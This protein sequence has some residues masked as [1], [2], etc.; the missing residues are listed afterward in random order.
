MS[1]NEENYSFTVPE[2]ESYLSIENYPY[3]LPPNCIFDKGKVGCGATTIALKCQHDYVIAVP[4]IFLIRNKVRQHPHV[5]GVDG[6]TSVQEIQK[7]HASQEIRT[8][9]VTY[10][11]LE[12][13]MEAVDTSQFKLLV[14]EYHLLFTHYVFR[15]KAIKKVLNNFLKFKEYCFMSATPIQPDFLLEELQGI[16]IVTA[17]WTNIKKVEIISVRCND[18]DATISDK[19]RRFLSG[20]LD[21]NAYIFVNS[22]TTI[23]S[24][25]TKNKLTAENTRVIYSKNNKSEVGIERSD[26]DSEPKKINLL[27]SAA[28][29]GADI[30]DENGKT[31][32][33]SNHRKRNTLIDISTSVLQISGRIRNTKYG[34]KVYHLYSSTR[35]SSDVTY[36]D[37]KASC[38]N[39]IQQTCED[40]EKLNALSESTKDRIEL[41]GKSGYLIKND[42]NIFKYDPNLFRYDLYNFNLTRLLYSSQEN[43]SQEYRNR[44]F[45]VK[46]Q[47]STKE[48]VSTTVP[49]E[50]KLSYK[51]KVEYVRQYGCYER[52]YG[53]SDFETQEKIADIFKTEPDLEEAILSPSIGFTGIAKTSYQRH[54]VKRLLIKTRNTS[55]TKK[56][57]DLLEEYGL[58]EAMFYTNP[59][60]TERLAKVYKE[61]DFQGSSTATGIK[62]F[63]DT[64]P[65]QQIIDGRRQKGFVIIR[66]HK[67]L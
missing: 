43:L 15:E 34:D 48:F 55:K 57:A 16:P 65:A 46:H 13:L 9:M 58:Q 37:Y 3:G 56:V 1:Q 31:Y 52:L 25:I 35:Y 39:E 8:Y 45:T 62:K 6:D 7:Y 19:I 27:T 29:E 47:T 14:D 28:F 17:V 50:P 12:K 32:I 33:I 22:V 18:V 30:L 41:K 23:E 54:L 59:D 63:F 20:A 36:E 21:G 51:A 49:Q 64:K 53:Y 40:A 4:L 61:V 24:L 60:I 42:D 26:I 10:D 2:G 38:E 44:G 66:K 11:S 67:L 5:C